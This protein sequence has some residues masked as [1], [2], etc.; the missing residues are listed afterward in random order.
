MTRASPDMFLELPL[1]SF[2]QE[3][4]EIICWQEI[5]NLDLTAA[6]AGAAGLHKI[7]ECISLPYADD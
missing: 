4:R 2:I 6:Q 3:I 5:S 7:S 1:V